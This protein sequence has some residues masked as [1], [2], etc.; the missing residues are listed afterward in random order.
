MNKKNIPE[1]RFPEFDGEWESKKLGEITIKI[2]DGLHGTPKYSE[3]TGYYFINGNN[4]IEGK[5]CI[6]DNT[7]E[8]SYNEYNANYKGLTK[9]TLLISI[10]GTIGNVA[11]FNDETVMLGKSIGYFIFKND[12]SFYFHLLKTQTVQKYFIS[13]LTGTTIK[14]LSL[15]TL[16][17]TKL[18]VPSF[19]EQTKIANFLTTVDKKITQLKQKKALLEKYKKGMM[20]K[21]FSQ[22]IRFKDENG[23]DFAE[24]KDKRLKE[25]FSLF[26]GFAFSSNDS[27]NEGIRWIKIA[28]VGIQTMRRDNLSYLPKY[29]VNK[30]NKFILKKG[31][32]VIALTRP[33]LN[34]KLK[35][36]LIDDF[37]NNS[38]LN[39]RVGKLVS[40]KNKTFIYHMLQQKWLIK[41]IENNIMGTD[42]PN[43]SPKE[44]GYIKV[45]VPKIE[46]QTKIANFLTKLDDKINTVDSQIK[47]TELWK[48]GLLQR[49]F[50]G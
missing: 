30:Y 50:C 31:D 6:Y 20:Q 29:Y 13:E 44:I 34:D 4:L 14:N 43:L 9:N 28:D 21:I 37:F 40:K 15:K 46:E 23:E 41:S 3:N 12:C 48:K 25:V 11:I 2:G 5:V 24:W 49:M 32:Y 27:T 35:I 22:E 47:K 16:R 38:L 17:E 8:I 42:P 10:N 18:L 45:E 33:I 19:P 1:L 36:A 7:K 39:Q 26:N